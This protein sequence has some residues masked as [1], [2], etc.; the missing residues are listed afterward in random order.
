MEQYIQVQWTSPDIEEARIICKYLVEN[1]MVACAN[2]I[3]RIESFYFWEGEVC[4]DHENKILL[5]TQAKLWEK[6][7]NIITTHSSNEVS[8]ILKFPISDGLPAYLEWIKN[9]TDNTLN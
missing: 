5:K 7:R 1:H 9:S 6:V 4:H 8:E 3:P 2:I